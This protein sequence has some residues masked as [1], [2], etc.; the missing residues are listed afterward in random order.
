MYF[1]KRNLDCT[2]NHAHFQNINSN[3][4]SSGHMHFVKNKTTNKN[5][6]KKRLIGKVLTMYRNYFWH[7]SKNAFQKQN[8]LKNKKFSAEERFY[9]KS[10]AKY[11]HQL[12]VCNS[13]ASTARA[14]LIHSHLR[15]PVFSTSSECNVI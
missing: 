15:S 9:L 12:L 10:L 13:R 6:N 7:L 8:I 5:N 11:V 1:C 3:N 2:D 14:F 4:M